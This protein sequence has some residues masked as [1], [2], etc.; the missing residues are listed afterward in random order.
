VQ[1]TEVECNKFECAEN[2]HQKWVFVVA[3]V[4][5]FGDVGHCSERPK[6]GVCDGYTVGL[7]TFGIVPEE[8]RRGAWR[9]HGRKWRLGSPT[10]D[11]HTSLPEGE[12]CAAVMEES[13]AGVRDV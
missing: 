9:R 6:E 10:Q 4:R 11:G 2:T 13:G 3:F 5:S 1:Q 8:M 7:S 12:E